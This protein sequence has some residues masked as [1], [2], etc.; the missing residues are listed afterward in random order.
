MHAVNML[1]AESTL[2]SLVDAIEQGEV[3]EIIIARNVGLRLNW[4]LWREPSA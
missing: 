4:R 2:S 1:R 3:R